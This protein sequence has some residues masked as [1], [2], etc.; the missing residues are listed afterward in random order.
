MDLTINDAYEIPTKQSH[1]N[2]NS[3]GET[4]KTVADDGCVSIMDY[5]GMFIS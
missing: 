4:K 1:H 3:L 5:F 2:L